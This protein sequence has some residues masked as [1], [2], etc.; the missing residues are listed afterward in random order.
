MSEEQGREP[1]PF[2][3]PPLYGC[4]WLLGCTHASLAAVGITAL[5]CTLDRVLGRQ[6]GKKNAFNCFSSSKAPA[7]R[8]PPLTQSGSQ[9]QG[10]L[11]SSGSP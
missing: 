3:Y 7:Q 11:P 9:N 8:L 5:P 1:V 6:K 2:Y 10:R 4:R